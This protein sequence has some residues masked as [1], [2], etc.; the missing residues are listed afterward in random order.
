MVA[1]VE[2][3]RDRE[4]RIR[5]YLRD[6]KAL[7][8][9]PEDAFLQNRERQYAILHALQL[10][11]EASVDI[12]T[13]ICAADDL[14]IPASYAEAFDLLEKHGVLDL[15]LAEEMRTMARFRNRIVHF[16]GAVDLRIV[17][18]VA[19]ERLSDFNRYLAAIERY[20]GP[21][22]GGAPKA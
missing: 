5:T 16:Y 15:A 20:L 13:H 4:G 9:M 12:A 11:I 21:A 19:Q 14:G 8:A 18:R 3:V 10:A 7:S 17:Y 2:V 6:L 1:D 22:P